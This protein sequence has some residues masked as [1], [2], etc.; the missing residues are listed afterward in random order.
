LEVAFPP[1][2]GKSAFLSSVAASGAAFS[3]A[4]A[5]DGGDPISAIAA[6]A[7]AF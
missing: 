3:S 2:T 4:L 6:V 5:A 1:T 7:L